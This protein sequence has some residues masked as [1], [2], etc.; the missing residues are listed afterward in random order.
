[1][2]CRTDA[3]YL[4]STCEARSH[5]SHVRVW[6]CEVCEQAPAAVTC[7]ADAATLCVTCDADIHAANPLARRHE[8]VPVVPVGN[9]TVQVKEDLFGED[10]EGD[11]WKGMMVDLNCFGGFSNELVDPYL[12]L[13]GNGDGLVPVQE[14]HV[15]GYGYR[16]EKGTMMPKGTVD[17]DFGAVGKGDGY[18]CG[19]GG[20]TVGVQSM[21]HSTTV[22]SSEAGVVPDNSSSMAVADV[23][24]PYSRPLP[25]PMD[26]MDREARVMR[27]REK[28]KNRKFEK[29]IR[30]ASRKAYAET[31]PRIKGRF[32]KRVDNDSYADPM[33]SVIN[34]STAFM[35]DSGYGVVPSF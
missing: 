24:N 33:H 3:T 35:N 8:R 16:Q 26:A 14:K 2:Y 32:A 11:T 23:S 9:P 34:A 13:D 20:Y 5:S 4:C 28:R 17:I 30:Y 10:G 29:T 7:K 1:M 22:S 31:R 19:H 15:Y 27:Y 6:L 25:N 18:G 12:D 21:S